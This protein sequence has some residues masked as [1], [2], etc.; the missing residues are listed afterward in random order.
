MIN[1][2]IKTEKD[3]TLALKRIETLMDAEADTPEAD[4]LELLST[5]VEMYEEKQY[6][7][8]LPDPV[9]AIRFRMAQLGLKQQ[10]LIPFMGSG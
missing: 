10:D 9:E 6:L 8:D 4:E 5:L 7:I 3:Y 2:L 1:R